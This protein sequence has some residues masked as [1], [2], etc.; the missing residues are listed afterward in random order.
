MSAAADTPGGEV[1]P[2]QVAT[3]EADSLIAELEDTAARLRRGD[4]GV[5]EAAALVERCAD[6]A[7]RLGAELERAARRAEAEPPL[8]QETL[9]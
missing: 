2:A 4:L 6:L 5:D 7:A 1:G 9:L 8:G 3:A